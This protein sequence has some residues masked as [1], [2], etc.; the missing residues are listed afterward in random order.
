MRHL[1]FILCSGYPEKMNKAEMTAKITEMVKNVNINLSKLDGV[2]VQHSNVVYYGDTKELAK[3]NPDQA[4]VLF[5]V[6]KE[7][8]KTTWTDVMEA[9]NEIYAPHY[10]FQS[11]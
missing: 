2:H 7:G 4:R 5:T 3:T 10:K 8:R 6:Q 1:T 9:V 11:F